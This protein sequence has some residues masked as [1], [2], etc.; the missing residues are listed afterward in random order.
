MLPGKKG[1]RG[2]LIKIGLH[3]FAT[4][5]PEILVIIGVLFFFLGGGKFLKQEVVSFRDAEMSPR[6]NCIL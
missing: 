5:R 6:K 3:F 1:G 2:S 4:V